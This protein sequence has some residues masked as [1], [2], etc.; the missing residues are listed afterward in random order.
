MAVTLTRTPRGASRTPGGSAVPCSNRLRKGGR[1]APLCGSSHPPRS[2]GVLAHR[3]QAW[4]YSPQAKFSPFPFS[5]PY[6]ASGGSAVP[7]SNRLRKGG[8][9]PPLREFASPAQ[10]WGACTPAASEGIPP[11]RGGFSLSFPR[12]SLTPRG[13]FHF[14]TV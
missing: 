7:C 11:Q 2:R 3:R 9:P 14:L 12:A 8:R 10:P 5:A 1:P 13:R 6:G 4:G